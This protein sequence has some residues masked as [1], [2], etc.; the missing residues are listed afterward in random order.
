MTA[1]KLSLY[2]GALH[3]IGDRKLA[4]LSE[5][6]ESRRVLDDIW[7]RGAVRFCLEQGFWNFAMR[8]VAIEY[9]PSVEPPFGYR[10]AFDKPVDWI[11]TAALC[12]DAYFNVPLTAY[13]DE[14]GFWFADLSPIFVQYVSDDLA[15]GGDFSLWTESFRRY[16]EQYLASRGCERLSQNASKQ[17]KIDGD[18]KR[19]LGNARSKDAMNSG[20]RFMPRGTWTR[21]RFGDYF[22]GRTTDGSW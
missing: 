9:S 18:M 16:V 5:N 12:Q 13:S 20:A 3:I 4:S 11:R 8:T 22:S 15:Y 14:A 19:I 17:E 1:D 6:R 21:S 7:D 2:N 10:Y